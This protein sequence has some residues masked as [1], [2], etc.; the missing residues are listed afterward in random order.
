MSQ[1]EVKTAFKTRSISD[2]R[3]KVQDE[4]EDDEDEED[5]EDDAD[6]EDDEDDE[7]SDHSL[8]STGG[9]AQHQSHRSLRLAK[10]ISK[11]WN[12]D[13]WMEQRLRE[14]LDP[15]SLASHGILGTLLKIANLTRCSSSNG[16]PHEVWKALQDALLAHERSMKTK[17]SKGWS[18][19]PVVAKALKLIQ[20]Q[21]SKEFNQVQSLFTLKPSASSFN[22]NTGISAHSNANASAA[23]SLLDEL[24]EIST[25]RIARNL[26]DSNRE[27]MMNRLNV[28]R[29][30]GG[31]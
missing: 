27:E 14:G 30:V 12:S 1:T 25:S 11:C 10:R 29:E 3:H 17:S 18:Q 9:S 26:S 20:K 21:K 19:G 4:D 8:N 31:Q 2:I 6:D 28:L 15:I 24:Q 5:N 7:A 13:L 16:F 22:N 23:T